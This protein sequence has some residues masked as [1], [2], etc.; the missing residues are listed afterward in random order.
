M[1]LAY[2]GEGGLGSPLVHLSGSS[3]GE[4][5]LPMYTEGIK[6]QKYLRKKLQKITF[7]SRKSKSYKRRNRNSSTMLDGRQV[8][9]KIEQ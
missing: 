9:D 3:R 1:G 7:T 4:D 2:V 6:M 8:D 5:R